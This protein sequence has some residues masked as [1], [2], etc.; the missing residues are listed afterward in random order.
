V[1]HLRIRGRRPTTGYLIRGVDAD[2]RRHDV[3]LAPSAR[4]A[5][6][7]RDAKRNPWVRT[8]IYGPSG[9]LSSRDLD[10]LADENH[11]FSSP[12]LER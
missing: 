3:A 2:G 1:T 8:E 12:E 6:I 10:R 4:G 9:L 7:Y 11:R 5:R